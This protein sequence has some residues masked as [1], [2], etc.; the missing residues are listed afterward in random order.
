MCILLGQKRRTKKMLLL[1][2]DFVV[3][4]LLLYVAGR[5][6]L[7]TSVPVPQGEDSNGQSGGEDDARKGETRPGQARPVSVNPI[8]EDGGLREAFEVSRTSSSSPL[9]H[10]RAVVGFNFRELLLRAWD[11]LS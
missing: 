3:V 7:V 2:Q 8:Q 10:G 11:S 9:K 5:E 4:V 6:N 1:R